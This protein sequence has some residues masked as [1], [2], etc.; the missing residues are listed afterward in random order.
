MVFDITN[1]NFLLILFLRFLLVLI[2]S[3]SLFLFYFILFYFLFILF[4][5]I[6]FYFVLFCFV[7]FCFLFW[8][9]L[10]LLFLLFFLFFSF[11]LFDFLLTNKIRSDLTV[12]SLEQKW[13]DFYCLLTQEE[14][15]LSQVLFLKEFLKKNPKRKKKSERKRKKQKTK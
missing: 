4:C 11:F 13:K 3:I 6:L 14:V 15:S 12:S 9:S 7:L 5:F 1:P 2:Q 8:F 10:F